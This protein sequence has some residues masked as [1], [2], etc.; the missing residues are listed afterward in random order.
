MSLKVTAGE[1]KPNRWT[2]QV[3]QAKAALP[4]KVKDAK[5]SAA[6]AGSKVTILVNV[7][8]TVRL[9]FPA[10]G[11][12]FPIQPGVFQLGHPKPVV[13]AV[14]AGEVSIVLELAGDAELPKTIRGVLAIKDA[15][16][17]LIEASR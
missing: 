12:F 8:S 4:R 15:P 9:P 7:D 11:A 2:K 5:I 3:A 16:S 1:P 10:T 13:S 14:K 6:V 17:L